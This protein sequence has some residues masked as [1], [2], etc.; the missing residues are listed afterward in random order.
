[1]TAQ[2]ELIQLREAKKLLQEQVGLQKQIIARQQEH[3]RLLEQQ[4]AQQQEQISLLVKENSLLDHRV[5][6]LT[7]EV[8]HLTEQ[9]KTLQ[10]RLV[11]DSHNSH[12][13]PSSDRFGRQPKSLRQP[14]GK[15]PGGQPGHPGQSLRFAPVPDEIITHTVE[16]C[17]CCKLDLQNIL[18]KAL[19]R[20]QVIDLPAPRVVVQEHRSEQKQCPSCSQITVAPFPA[21]VRAPIQYGASIGAIAVYLAEQQLLPLARACEVMQDLLGIAM[22][23]ATLQGLIARCSR[24]LETVE[25]QIKQALRQAEVIHQDETGLHVANRRQ[26]MHVTSTAQLTHYLVHP[27]RGR[28]ALDAIG[29]LS[30]FTGTGVHD[31]WEAYGQ[32]ACA[33]AACN[34][35]IL[36][37]LTFL[38][39]EQGLW[40]AAKLKALLVDMKE[41]TEQA[42]AQRKHWL[43]PLEVVD[44]QA[45]YLRL[46]DEGDQTH[47]RA[48][49]PPGHRGRVKQSKARNLL[50]RVNGQ[51]F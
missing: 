28:K 47:P 38:S 40:W 41:A 11:K 30:H 25:E 32:Y 51:P 27:S 48:T 8:K 22:S 10:E 33:H 43:H 4:A 35:H 16:F 7:E 17:S 5:R 42:R 45:R 15:E 19:E 31:G 1:M 13:P 36:R 9:V 12:Q 44:W 20:R 3:I 2:E 34:V 21:E 26:W 39:E 18:P 24:N 49:A 50:D 29:I 46:L 37:E 14:S 23:E 6:Q